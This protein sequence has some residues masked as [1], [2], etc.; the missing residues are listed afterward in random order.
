MFIN[1][2]SFEKLIIFIAVGLVLGI[3]YDS[4]SVIKLAIKKNILVVNVLDFFYC[5]ICGLI[6]IYCIFKFNYGDIAIFELVCLLFGIIFEQ[7]I[8][9]N[10]WTSPLKWVYNKINLKRVKKK[11]KEEILGGTKDD[12]SKID[13]NS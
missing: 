12:T 1:S 3:I 2:V 10:L 7:I 6:F 9:K 5:L 8:V 4:L 13:T 11:F